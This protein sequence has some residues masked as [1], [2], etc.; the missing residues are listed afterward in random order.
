LAPLTT[1]PP[2]KASFT[3][4]AT[5]FTRKIKKLLRPLRR[6]YL[7]LIDHPIALAALYGDD[8]SAKGM[9]IT[10][11]LCSFTKEECE[12]IAEWLREKW[13]VK[14]RVYVERS[15]S[16]KPYPRIML[17]PKAAQRFMNLIRPY[18][19]RLF[20]EK[21][22]MYHRSVERAREYHRKYMREYRRRRKLP[23]DS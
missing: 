3:V 12:M 21:L 7:E 6:E 5:D 18:L 1:G 13:G 14:A 10:L 4:R 22:E 23:K 2:R 8:G 17:P 11:S 15:R 20:P 16:G 9:Q 19:A